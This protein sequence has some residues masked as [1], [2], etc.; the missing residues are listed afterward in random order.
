MKNNLGTSIELE[1][2]EKRLQDSGI[3]ISQYGKCA[4]K[5]VKDLLKE[6]QDKEII[7]INDK[8][9]NLLRKVRVGSIDIFYTNLKEEKFFLREEKQ[10]FKD[11]RERRRNLPGSVS[12][13]IRTN[14]DPKE[15]V[16]R[17]IQE[18]LGIPTRLNVF[19]EEKR[20]EKVQSPSYPGLTSEYLIHK[21]SANI[22]DY[23][24]NPEGYIE[25]GD[26]LTTFFVWKKIR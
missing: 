7:L 20:I 23:D 19:E 10:V 22:E 11:G 6:I 24:F 16:I 4:A 2:L 12:G 15:S 3:N 14:E 25:N 1:N 21:F 17:E 9:G 5:T 8:N 18:E 13:K 26:K